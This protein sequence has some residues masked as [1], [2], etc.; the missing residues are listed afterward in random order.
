MGIAVKKF[1]HEHEELAREIRDAIVDCR[2]ADEYRQMKR[3][4]EE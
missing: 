4:S 1:H 3:K 2:S